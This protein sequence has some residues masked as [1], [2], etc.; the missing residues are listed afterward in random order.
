MLRIGSVAVVAGFAPA[1]IG[2]IP[3]PAI[4]HPA[5]KMNAPVLRLAL[6]QHYGRPGDASGYSVILVTGRRTAWVFGGSN[7][8]GPSTPVAARWTGK[9]LSPSALP[10]KLTGF[11][12]EAGATSSHD[13]WAASQ[14]GRYVL[15]WNGRQW[16]LVRHFA[17]GSITG[18]TVAGQ[19]SVWV[20]TTT[21]GGVHQEGTW[22]F[23]GHAWMHPGGL[24]SQI[25][26]ASAL[27]GHDIWAVAVGGS[28]DMIVRFDGKR[29]HHVQTGRT[30]A[31]LRVHDILAES[32]RDVWVAGNETA[33][34]GR[35]VLA[36]WNGTRWTRIASKL[37]A[38]AGRLAKGR[39]GGVLLT[40][41]PETGTAATGSVLSVSTDGWITD[42]VVR[43]ARGTGVSDVAEVP[44]RR[45]VLVAGGLLTAA[46]G[47]AAFW[48]GVFPVARP[49][50]D[51]DD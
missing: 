49:D 45:M 33:G 43:S 51:D 26:R 6:S 12:S 27:S 32:D 9:S 37:D 8:G 38:W 5:A 41:T 25:N 34:A 20:F 35:L 3:G 21:A 28:A 1:A 24:A 48:S 15:H 4:V 46:G 36:H 50:D 17:H 2:G 7:P 10:A 19:H 14:F 47:N 18:L 16:S 40:A 29:W 23:N 11:I 22:H 39:R 42:A 31:G 44:D 30:L 13:I